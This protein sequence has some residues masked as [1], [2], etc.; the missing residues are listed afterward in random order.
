M[1]KR[2]QPAANI[3]VKKHYTEEISFKLNEIAFITAA[4]NEIF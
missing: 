1:N 2:A 3:I 4:P